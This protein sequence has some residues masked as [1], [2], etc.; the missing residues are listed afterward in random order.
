MRNSFWMCS[1]IKS[2]HRDRSVLLFVF[3]RSYSDRVIIKA[4]GNL[5]SQFF[6]N[7]ARK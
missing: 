7:G 6:G 2:L 1:T 4:S 3:P 5:R